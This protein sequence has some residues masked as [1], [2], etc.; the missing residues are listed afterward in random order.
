MVYVDGCTTTC[1]PIA[2]AVS[3]VI[4]PMQA[5]RTRRSSGTASPPSAATKDRTVLELVND[6]VDVANREESAHLINRWRAGT[7]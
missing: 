4:G 2:R 6:H 7:V 1:R 5:I 3:A